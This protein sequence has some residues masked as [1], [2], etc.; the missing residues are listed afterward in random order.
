[1]CFDGI[2]DGTFNITVHFMFPISLANLGQSRWFPC[3]DVSRHKCIG[4]EMQFAAAD[5][6]AAGIKEGGGM[7]GTCC[8]RWWRLARKVFNDRYL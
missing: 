2:I 4:E 6:G 5:V 7:N 1:V 3:G 8:A